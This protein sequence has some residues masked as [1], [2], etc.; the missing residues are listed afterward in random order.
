MLWITHSIEEALFLATRHGRDDG[1]SGPHQ[2]RASRP[3]SRA[4]SD[5]LVA[6]T[7]EFATAKRTVFGLLRQEALEAQRQEAARLSAAT[8]AMRASR[9]S[10]ARGLR[11][12]ASVRR[13]DGPRRAS[14][15]AR[16]RVV[17]GHARAL[18]P[19]H[20]QRAVAAAGAADLPA[21]AD[22]RSR[23]TFMTLMQNGYQGKTLAHHLGDQPDPLR[24]R[25]RVCVAGRRAGRPADGH[26]QQR[27]GG[28]RSA[29]R[30][31]AA[32]AQA[33]AAAA[34]DH[35]VRHRRVSKTIVIIAALF[36][37]ISIS[38]MQAVRA[39]GCARSRRRWRSAPRAR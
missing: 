17:R 18:V 36:P 35:L 22:R 39:V 34:V 2:G 30:D 25:V 15:L 16:P 7:A 26:E 32:D 6:T 21:L 9:W 13:V 20:R 31:H 10:D 12:A 19:D 1:A 23:K 27:E 8:S 28:A 33:R 5:P 11:G 29:D 37:M 4:T 14:A 24:P 3:R 38:A